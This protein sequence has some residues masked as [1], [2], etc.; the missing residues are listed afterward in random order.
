MTDNLLIVETPYSQPTVTEWLEDNE[1]LTFKEIVENLIKEGKIEPPSYDLP[2]PYLSVSQVELYLKCPKQFEFRYVYGHKKP[3][4]AALVQGK[5]IH[6]VLEKGYNHIK[7]KKELPP[8][9]YILDN[10]SDTIKEAL[11]YDEIVYE[12]D[13]DEKIIRKQGE[14]LLKKWR[15]VKAPKV[16]P[17][18]VEKAF[19]MNVAGV[20]AVGIIDLIDDN[21]IVDN[22]VVAK[23]WS[24]DRIDNS[25]QLTLYSAATGLNEQRI[26]LYV[27][28]STA[29]LVNPN[30]R[31]KGPHIKE[32]SS[33]RSRKDY[34]W[35]AEV[36][37]NVAKS[38]SAGIFPPTTPDSWVCTKKW[39]GFWDMCR[40]KYSL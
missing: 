23:S 35:M 20:P 39:C 1:E 17:K 18:E 14:S 4:S 5:A 19:V 22:K 37:E 13:E 26:D 38:I 31:A 6:N 27:K 33:K 25:L 24:Q 12:E 2:L 28:G 32:L 8:E 29:A 36:F 16:S 21:V 9:E 11:E 30:S 40:G 7:T 10:Y 3:P 15:E 34:M